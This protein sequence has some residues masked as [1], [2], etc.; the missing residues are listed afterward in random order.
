MTRVFEFLKYSECKPVVSLYLKG[1]RDWEY[2]RRQYI[3]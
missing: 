2:S 1:M 3:P